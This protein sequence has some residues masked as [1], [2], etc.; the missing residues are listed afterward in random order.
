MS[1]EAALSLWLAVHFPALPI[2]WPGCPA[3]ARAPGFLQVMQLAL[4]MHAGQSLYDRLPIADRTSGI[5]Q[6]PW[7]A[8]LL[9]GLL[10]WASPACYCWR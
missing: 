9:R 4:L 10:H 8:E 3:Y 5:L 6:F 7:A 1:A 2:H